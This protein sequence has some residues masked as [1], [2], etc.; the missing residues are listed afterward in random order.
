M[1]TEVDGALARPDGRE[2]PLR[3][4]HLLHT[5]GVGGME[6]GIT[7]LVNS[8]DRSRIASSICSCRPGDSLK[9][10]LRPDIPLYEFNR[11]EGNDPRLVVQLVRLFRAKRPDVIHTHRWATLLEG[12]I[13]A[14]LAGVPFVVHGEH[15]TLETRRH[16]ALV[17]RT[18]W[19]RVD[20]VL[21]V[22]SRLAE[23]MAR[24]IGFRV[25]R[26]QVIRNGVDLERFKPEQRLEA[27]ASFGLE[28]HQIVI[29]SVGR[30]VP[31]KDQAT[32]L[33]ALALL[34]TSG[35]SFMG[36]LAGAGPLHGELQSLA[37]ALN[38]DNVSLLGNRNDVERVL[39]ALDVFVLSSLSEGL[40]NTIQEAMATGLPVVATRVGG[41]DELV[42]HEHTGCLVPPGDP[43]ALAEAIASLV[44]DPA[45]R[46]RFAQ[47]GIERARQH[48]GLDRMI[49][50]Y[51]QMYLDL[52][53]RR[54]AVLG[55]AQANE[56]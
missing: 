34:R 17:Q 39:G 19:N 53:R 44:R 2:R 3:V 10:R 28:P 47:A 14:R 52:S 48:F 13:A 9:Q 15:G 55:Y 27:R 22:S 45:R 43:R 24:D 30:L 8:L 54:P 41:A 37:A 20:R 23:R 29:G 51:E 7:K 16:N 46:Q 32:L 12:L 38:L 6:V 25:D 21:S 4:M 36:V 5:F 26:I 1:N 35:F 50:E 42:E 11:R 49:R 56:A 33:R 40:S 31:V 18:V